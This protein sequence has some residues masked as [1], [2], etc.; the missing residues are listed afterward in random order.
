MLPVPRERGA[1]QPRAATVPTAGGA[2]R[3][4]NEETACAKG[5]RVCPRHGMF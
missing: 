1:L 4:A 2:G 3:V 5:L